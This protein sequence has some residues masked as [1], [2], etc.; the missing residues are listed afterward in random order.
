MAKMI[1]M[2]N[3]E[4]KRVS[5]DFKW[6]LNKVWYGYL[7]NDCIDDR[8]DECKKYAKIMKIEFHKSGC[9]DYKKLY[10]PPKGDGYQCWETTSEGS[11]ISPVFK[12]LDDLCDWL[13]N[14]SGD[15]ILRNYTKEDWM[16]ILQEKSITMDM[17][18]NKPA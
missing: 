11:P 1:M 5:L 14:N 10:D 4:L 9:P 6:E 3:R 7:I 18:T 2:V 12:T 16:D 15:T 17:D 8:C 13:A